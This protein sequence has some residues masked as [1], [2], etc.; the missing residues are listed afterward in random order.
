MLLMCL[1]I[2]YQTHAGA[3][4]PAHTYVAACCVG[5]DS[6][7]PS[8]APGP[9]PW[10]GFSLVLCC[11]GAGVPLCSIALLWQLPHTSS[12]QQPLRG[13]AAAC[14]PMQVI[15]IPPVLPLLPSIKLRMSSV[16][17]N[18]RCASER[19]MPERYLINGRLELMGEATGFL[20]TLRTGE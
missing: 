1:Q 20:Q 3:A 10:F 17:L 14:L 11:R 19:K 4:Q 12:C 5:A 16:I 7:Q 6:S 18:E 8:C 13:P 2:N 9:V 15:F